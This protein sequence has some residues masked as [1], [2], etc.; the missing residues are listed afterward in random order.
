MGKEAG[1]KEGEKAQKKVSVATCES[2]NDVVWIAHMPRGVQQ[3]E[4][5]L[6]DAVGS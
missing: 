5:G 4:R 6:C 3:P 2:E 1:E